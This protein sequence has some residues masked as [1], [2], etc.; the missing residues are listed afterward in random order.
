MVNFPIN[1]CIVAFGLELGV[2]LMPS[3]RLLVRFGPSFR[4]GI[5]I[6]LGIGLRVGLRSRFWLRLKLGLRLGWVGI[7]FV[8]ITG[9]SLTWAKG[10]GLGLASG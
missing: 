10:Q 4:L 6:R 1:K 9:S 8:F 3:F 2:K 5:G 7:R